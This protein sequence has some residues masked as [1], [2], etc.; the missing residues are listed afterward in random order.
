MSSYIVP[1]H[2]L[3][4]L[5]T[6]ANRQ[7]QGPRA[8]TYYWQGKR[9]NFTDDIERCASVLYAENVRSV[10]ARYQDDTPAHGFV[11]RFVRVE[12]LRPVDIIKA[13]HGY[14]YQACDTNDWEQSE[15]FAM[16]QA[17]EQAAIRALPGYDDS[18]AWCL[19]SVVP[20]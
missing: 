18:P 7:G 20:A 16:V 19:D 1:D 8:V 12:H 11:F 5:I 14:A 2:H 4:T 3:N 13:C 10:N 9:R 6:W 17:I 15:A